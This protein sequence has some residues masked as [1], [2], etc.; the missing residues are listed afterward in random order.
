MG[1]LDEV[2]PHSK[3]PTLGPT[4]MLWHPGL[5]TAWA[6]G[7]ALGS[8]WCSVYHRMLPVPWGASGYHEIFLTPGDALRTAGCFQHYRMLP[9]PG[10]TQSGRCPWMQDAWSPVRRQQVPRCCH[11]CPSSITR[12]RPSTP[13]DISK[14]LI[15]STTSVSLPHPQGDQ[16][17]VTLNPAAY[18]PPPRPWHPS[19]AQGGHK[20]LQRTHQFPNSR[21]PMGAEAGLGS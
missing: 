1:L 15:S 19:G 11:P 9:A 5:G 4:C 21:V 17:L 12:L 8:A 6:A 20:H 13:T 2:G 3:I 18:H 10:D 7:A 14:Q 16:G